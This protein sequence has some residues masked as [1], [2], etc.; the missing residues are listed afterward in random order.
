[1]QNIKNHVLGAKLV[2]T[3]QILC[4]KSLSADGFYSK[5]TVESQQCPWRDGQTLAVYTVQK[6]KAGGAG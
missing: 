4:F 6:Y 2:H 1:M 5:G 3:T